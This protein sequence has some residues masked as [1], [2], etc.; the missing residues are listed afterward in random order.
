MEPFEKIYIN[1]SFLETYHGEIACEACHGGNPKDPNWQTA[2]KGVVKDPTFPDAKKTCGECHEDI[3]STAKSSLHYTLAPFENAIKTRANKKDK[4]TLKK[5]LMAKDRHCNSC[6]SSCGQCHVSRPNY[7]EGGFLAGH[8]FQKKPSME[9]TCASCHGG[10]V[11]AEFTGAN[12]E[13]LADVHYDKKEMECMDCH[14]GEEMHSDATGVNTRFDLPKRP[15]CEKCH[16]DVVSDKPKPESH[17][18]HKDKVACQVCH[19]Q[20]YKNCFNCHVGTDKKGLPYFKSGETKMLFKVGLNP[21]K[22]NDRPHDY[23]VLRHPPADPKLFDYYIKNGLTDFDKLPTWKLETPHNIQRITP[24]NKTCNNCHGNISLF[25]TKK[26]VTNFELKANIGTVV[27]ENKI[28]N[29]IKEV[30][31]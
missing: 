21:N 2:H 24:Q 12:D 29:R 4:E 18:I 6:H 28:P 8:A 10:R 22:T 16:P 1:P 14:T 9:T 5:T 15:R 23:V 13:Y 27:P 30:I 25:L 26:D 17:S 7:V 20:A 11:Y 19:S 3:V 31:K